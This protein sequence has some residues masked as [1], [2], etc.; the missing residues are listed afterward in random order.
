M[1]NRI[2]PRYLR[3]LP[4][5]TKGAVYM[6]AAAFC[7]SFMNVLVRAASGTIP[8]LEIAFF[9]NVFA[10]SFMLPWMF[11][12]GWRG[13][14]TTRFKLQLARAVTG[15]TVMAIWFTALALVPLA[16]AV[17]LNFTLPLFVVAGA[18]IFLKEDV[19]ARRWIATAIGFSGMLVIIR[20]GFATIS[21]VMVL[22][23]VA[24]FLMAVSM[25]FLKRLSATESAGTNVLYMNVLMTPL[26]LIPALFVW[27]WP[28]LATLAL[29]GLLGLSAMLAH[30]ALARA[31][32]KADASAVTIFDY[33]RLPL[34][35]LFAFVLYGEVPLIWTWIG[36]AI[37]AGSAIYIVRR[38]AVL[39][40]TRN[41]EVPA[42]P[43]A[44]KR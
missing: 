9:R 39:A 10:V 32:S 35:A 24:A 42:A 26:S 22:P 19:G 29:L 3:D 6:L 40:A 28:D 43:A 38:E 5:M 12:T 33:M 34:I 41:T 13:L 30:L 17:A 44:I 37:I 16:D 2:L 14:R 1:W 15:A 27:R 8:P 7:F 4:D 31:Y 25:M 20:P 36:A 18:A 23:V 11:K 21:P